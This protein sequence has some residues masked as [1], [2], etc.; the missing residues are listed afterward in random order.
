MN[1]TR[2][3]AG[4]KK[5]E[6]VRWPV[7]FEVNQNEISYDV[8]TYL[9]WAQLIVLNKEKMLIVQMVGE[10]ASRPPIYIEEQAPIFLKNLLNTVVSECV[11][12]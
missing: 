7:Q 10:G 2:K 5:I 12:E 9:G 4:V 11:S 3:Y 8:E 1:V 6:R